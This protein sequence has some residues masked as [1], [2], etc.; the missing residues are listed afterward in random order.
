MKKAKIIFFGTPDFVVPVLD[1]LV[2][3][4][5]IVGVVTTP[6]APT[7]RKQILT[8]SPIKEKALQLGLPVLTPSKLNTDFCYHL[9]AT[10]CQ[11]IIVASY[12]KIIP[13]SILDIP[14]QGA[15]NIHPSLLPKYRGATPIPAVILAGETETG[16]SFI[17]M[18]KEMDHGPIIHQEKYSL[19]GKETSQSLLQEI[20]HQASEIAPKIITDY[21]SDQIQPQVQ[22][23]TQA[24]FCKMMIKE[25]GYFDIDSP[26]APEVLDRMIRGLFPWPTCWTKWSFGS[27]Q[28]KKVKVVKLL[29]QPVIARNKMTKQSSPNKI[30]TPR[31]S[32][33]R[34]DEAKI[35]IQLEGKNPVPLK[36]FL[37]GH[38][39][40]PLKNL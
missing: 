31:Q 19:T 4:F 7:G 37:H 27:A 28:D 22:D 5:T 16:I 13:Q 3:H 10:D 39:D 6:D 17:Q 32:G 11:L 18:D 9:R 24:T 20:W 38:P 40:F 8:P 21:L 25:D 12:G 23:H 1:A 34:N 35:L 14:T 36:D 26:P 15:I 29:P 33:V 2:Q 30:A